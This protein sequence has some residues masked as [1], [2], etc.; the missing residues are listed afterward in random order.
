MRIVL[1]LCLCVI[2]LAHT[3]NVDTTTIALSRYDNSVTGKGSS[4]VLE[5]MYTGTIAARCA[6][7]IAAYNNDTLIFING[8]MY[9]FSLINFTIVN[10]ITR[11]I[12][13]VEPFDTGVLFC[14]TERLFRINGTFI[15][16]QLGASS[17]K[18]FVQLLQRPYGTTLFK[19]I[20]STEK[21][22][23]N[24]LFW[25]EE[26]AFHRFRIMKL[27]M[28]NTFAEHVYESPNDKD[29]IHRVT[30]DRTSN[31]SH[32][33]FTINDQ[34][35]FVYNYKKKQEPAELIVQGKYIKAMDMYKSMLYWYDDKVVYRCNVGNYTNVKEQCASTIEK[36]FT[37]VG[38]VKDFAFTDRFV[39]V[40]EEI[41]P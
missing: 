19:L 13:L 9:S 23:R 41:L 25:C 27:E 31:E 29:L 17:S 4:S 14:S 32:L 8:N 11:G 33:F 35:I 36:L 21:S 16:A 7:G 10:T 2:A 12:P 30:M 34:Q 39:F 20:D 3:N 18:P 26:D 40:S 24:A 37:T 15:Y 1:F 38:I 28:P 22:S 5:R 6:Y